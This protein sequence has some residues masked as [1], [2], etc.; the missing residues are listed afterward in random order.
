M[1][2]MQSRIIALES[3]V[4]FLKKGQQ[5]KFS[6]LIKMKV[7]GIEEIKK[8]PVFNEIVLFILETIKDDKQPVQL[9]RGNLGDQGYTKFDSTI[10][11]LPL[12]SQLLWMCPS[13]MCAF[14]G[15]HILVLQKETGR[16]N[17]AF[18]KLD[19]TLEI[20]VVK[21]YTCNA[22]DMIGMV[23]RL[24]NFDLKFIV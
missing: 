14:V 9:D 12:P 2:V 11:I 18:C 6:G 3:L 16:V 1:E 19:L 5:K 23:K 4:E 15:Q 20:K 21:L 10:T 17:L 7:E 24:C 8:W 13:E 22:D